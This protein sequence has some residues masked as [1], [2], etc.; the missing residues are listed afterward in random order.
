[1]TYDQF[2]KTHSIITVEQFMAD[3]NR[4]VDVQ[5][6]PTLKKIHAYAIAPDFN[7]YILECA[8]GFHWSFMHPCDEVRSR[9]GAAERALF[10][11]HVE[12]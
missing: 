11:D 3:E 10:L 4:P 5:Y 8:D 2:R 1:M 7:F 12:Q 6:Y 9:L